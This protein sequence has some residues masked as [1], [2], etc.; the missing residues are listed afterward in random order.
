MQ[1]H[2]WPRCPDWQYV[3]VAGCAGAC[4]RRIGRNWLSLTVLFL[5]SFSGVTAHLLHF[6]AVDL[7]WRAGGH[8]PWGQSGSSWIFHPVNHLGS[9]R[10]ES[11][12]EKIFYTSSEPVQLSDTMLKNN[13]PFI[14]QYTVT[15]FSTCLSSI[16]AHNGNLQLSLWLWAGWAVLLCRPHRKLHLLKQ[17][18][19]KSWERI[20]KKGTG[21]IEKIEI[22][23]RKQF[24]AVVKA[25]NFDPRLWRENICQL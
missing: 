5:W 4:K 20:L 6:D 22:R 16:G 18:Q 1:H 19:L 8:V 17:T 15:H 14:C 10:N 25:V 9:P 11:H 23:T 24:L 7:R 2:H 21:R 3:T 12:A 13:C